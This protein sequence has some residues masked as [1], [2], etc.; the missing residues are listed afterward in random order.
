[1]TSKLKTTRKR[2]TI[3][4]ME[5]NP[6][7]TDNVLVKGCRQKNRLAQKYLY[8]RF[9]GKM[10]NICMRY[11]S[12]RYEAKE[13]L[14]T[15]FLKVF[16]SINSYKELGSLSGWIAKIVFYTTI[17]HIRANTNYKKNIKLNIEI[18][19][20]IEN[21]AISNLNTEVL[22]M[23]IQKLDSGRRSVFCMHVIDGYTHKEIGATLG[24]SEGTSKWYLS[25]ARKSIIERFQKIDL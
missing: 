11:T 6:F 18:E 22:Y 8:E 21:E 4:S 16:H 7:S 1:M 17:D 3:L 5:Y 25:E 12:N 13:I 9:A 24:I 23:I 15:A 19:T 2:P 14:N 10:I 20:P